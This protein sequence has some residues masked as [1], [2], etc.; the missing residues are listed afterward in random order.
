MQ[1]EQSP[2]VPTLH[3]L[4]PA[5]LQ[6]LQHA[7]DG[8][9]YPQPLPQLHPSAVIYQQ[10]Q[11]YALSGPPQPPPH[12]LQYLP[13]SPVQY[14]SFPVSYQHASS[15]RFAVTPPLPVSGGIPVQHY[16]PPPRPPQQHS[17]PPPPPPPVPSAPQHAPQAHREPEGRDGDDA[18]SSG[19]FQGLKL[20]AE[21]PDLEAWRQKLFDV[22]DTMTLNEDE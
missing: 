6:H 11:Q 8:S 3:R 10:Q 7:P 4:H 1:L 18:P 17:I 16:P 20:V 15:P 21:P 12:A 9:L 19:Q 5:S 13:G 14:T 2:P 22:D